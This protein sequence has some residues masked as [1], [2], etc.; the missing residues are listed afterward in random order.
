MVVMSLV[1]TESVPVWCCCSGVMYSDVNEAFHVVHVRGWNVT[2]MNFMMCCRF[3]PFF[4][5]FFLRV[6]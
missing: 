1:R 6:V 5:F 2:G 4:F 3:G